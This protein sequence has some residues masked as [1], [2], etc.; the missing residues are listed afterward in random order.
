MSPLSDPAIGFRPD[1]ISM[2]RTGPR[3]VVTVT[4]FDSSGSDSAG[5]PL[6]RFERGLCSEGLLA[7]TM[8]V[9]RRRALSCAVPLLGAMLLTGC[10]SGGGG[11]PTGENAKL[12]DKLKMLE[13]AKAKAAARKL[14]KK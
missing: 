12:P 2:A 8:R 6:S 14:K 13:D 9:S 4:C 3:D 5:R 7:M 1:W 11:N 10:G